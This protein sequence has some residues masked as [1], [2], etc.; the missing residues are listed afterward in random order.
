MKKIFYTL[1][2]AATIMATACKSNSTGTTGGAT[3]DSGATGSSGASDT[4]MAA[5]S[6]TGMGSS[7]GGSDTSTTGSNGGVTNPVTDTG[8]R[9]RP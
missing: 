8:A 3:A 2:F 9:Q 1:L 6:G 4:G 7:T 5:G